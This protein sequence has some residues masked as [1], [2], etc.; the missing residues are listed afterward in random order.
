MKTRYM[1]APGAILPDE[2]PD[3]GSDR[4]CARRL[5]HV[6][7]SADQPACGGLADHGQINERL[8]CRLAEVVKHYIF[9][10]AGNRHPAI[11]RFGTAQPLPERVLIGPELLGGGAAEDCPDSPTRGRVPGESAAAKKSNAHRLK[12]V[13]VGEGHI[14]EML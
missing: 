14:H 9:D 1:G 6:R 3:F 7:G 5:H 12:V 8:G 10:N 11:R 2:C 13:S 4:L